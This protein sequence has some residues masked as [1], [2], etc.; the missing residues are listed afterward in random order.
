MP[1]GSFLHR[2]MDLLASRPL[3][4]KSLTSAIIAGAGDIVAQA[5]ESK[6]ETS[7]SKPSSS[8]WLPPEQSKSDSNPTN[9]L[10]RWSPQRTIRLASFGFLVAAPFTHYW[11]ILLDRMFGPA[12][13]LRPAILKV[14]VDQTIMA[15]I[16]TTV[17]FT[18]HG[19]VQ[20][21]NARRIEAKLQSDL[22]PTLVANWAVWPAAL[23]VSFRFVPLDLRVLWMNVVGLG[24][25]T[26][27]SLVQQ[28]ERPIP[29]IDAIVAP[30]ASVEAVTV[31]ESNA[32]VKS[33]A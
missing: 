26:Y 18:F 31:R 11:Y 8:N 13:T 21:W 19:I 24:W 10:S 6:L 27:L 1:R 22:W 33:S 4:T 7:D 14:A 5:I 23:S 3:A 17:F 25:T 9:F 15:P 2:Y 16:S 20:G 12:M 32:V 29:S 30:V 28:R